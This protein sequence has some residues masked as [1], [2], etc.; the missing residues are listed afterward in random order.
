VTRDEALF[1]F[2]WHQRTSPLDTRERLL[3]SIG[4]APDR[5][6]LATCHRIEVYVAS[7]THLDIARAD[8]DA[9]TVYEGADALAHL[10]EVAAGL[11]SA[12]A[13]EPQILAQVRRAYMSCRP[14]D[15]RI[16]RAFEF[17]LHAGRTIRNELG[18]ASA[19][20]VGSIA[21]DRLVERLTRPQDARVLVV[22][23]G[24]MGKLAVR[25]LARRVGGVVVANRDLPRA[26]E[27][28][29]AHGATAIPLADAGA[30]I[31]SVDAVISAA[32]TRGRLLTADLLRERAG[33]GAFTLIDIAVPRSVDAE[34]REALAD[35]Y[36]S[37]DDLA[38]EVAIPAEKLA[39]AR[40]RCRG[41]ARRFLSERAPDRVDA[42]RVMRDEADRL[43]EARLRRAMRKLG[44]LSE[45]DRKVVERL[46]T[47]LTN[48]L[49]HRPTVELRER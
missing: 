46:A 44:H 12:I 24:E 28:A 32:D 11:D 42:I 35:A 19:R 39:S 17:A 34:G 21:V 26:Q 33:R 23:A 49:L 4:C 16:A 3:G 36:L 5:A 9:A 6:V 31:A 15:A 2:T 25:A 41:E 38:A 27:V 20:S 43:R 40:A 10:I 37:V 29:A 45:R 7:R 13:G 30:A 47:S 14:V 1:A 48:A 8:G 22:G 18:I